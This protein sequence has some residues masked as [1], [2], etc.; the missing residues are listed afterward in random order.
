MS[1][2]IVTPIRSFAGGIHSA[3]L[4]ARADVETYYI[5]ART[6]NN[7]FVM[8]SGAAAN[9]SGFEYIGTAK[10]A[11]KPCR[12]QEWIFDD[13]DRYILE[14]GESYIRFWQ[15]GGRI[16]TNG[17]TPQWDIATFYNVGDLV[18]E[19][20][21]GVTLVY[22]CCIASVGSPPLV[23]Q[24]PEVWRAMEGVVT[25]PAADAVGIF[26][27]PSPYDDAF[28]FALRFAQ[29]QDTTFIAHGRYPPYRLLRAGTTSW[30]MQPVNFAPPLNGP[31]NLAATKTGTGV[32]DAYKVTAVRKEKDEESFPGCVA[33]TTKSTSAITGG[34]PSDLRITSVNYSIANGTSIM[35]VRVYPLTGATN[36]TFEASLLNKTFTLSVVTAN[37]FD[38]TGSSGIT[39]AAGYAADFVALSSTT[40]TGTTTGAATDDCVVGATA[41]G[42]VTGDE[43]LIINAQGTTAEA[44]T[45]IVYKTW[46]VTVL[47]ANTFKLNDSKGINWTTDVGTIWFALTYVTVN[48]G[49]AGTVALTWDIV[50]EADKYYVS[51]RANGV[52]GYASTVTEVNATTGLVTW[53]DPQLTTA[54][55]GADT[56]DTPPKPFNDFRGTGRFPSTVAFHDDRLVWGATDDEPSRFWMS[57]V[58]DYL[59]YTHS[60]PIKD[61]DGISGTIIGAQELR[62]FIEIGDSLFAVS[63]R[64]LYSLDV[65]QDGVLTPDGVRARERGRIGASTVAPVKI[66]DSAL[67]VQARGGLVRDFRADLVEFQKGRD[68]TTYAPSLFDGHTIEQWAFQRDPHSILW[69]V[70]DD[71]ILVAN[72]YVREQE[73]A[74]WHTHD[75]GRD[76]YTGD[77]AGFESVA[78]IP[79]TIGESL[80]AVVNRTIGPSY[81]FG[82]KYEPPT[83]YRMI[84]WGYF[85]AENQAIRALH[86]NG[87]H[88]MIPSTGDV[89]VAAGSGN[90]Q[91]NSFLPAIANGDTVVCTNLWVANEDG[92]IGVPL[93]GKM[94]ESV[95]ANGIFKAA[96]IGQTFTVTAKASQHFE[97]S[98]TSA[99]AVPAS[100]R[101]VFIKTGNIVSAP[102]TSGA[103][104]NIGATSFG[105]GEPA[106]GA[107]GT[108]QLNKAL[109]GGGGVNIV[110]TTATTYPVGSWV[111]IIDV[112]PSA[113]SPDLVFEALLEGNFYLVSKETAGVSF[114]IAATSGITVPPT[115]RADFRRRGTLPSWPGTLGTAVLDK[116]LSGGAGA[117]VGG[118]NLNILVTS[119]TTPVSG[120]KILVMDVTKTAGAVQATFE[121]TLEAHVYTAI[122]VVAGVSF[123]LQGTSTITVPA[124]QIM[125]F[126]LI[127]GDVNYWTMT[128]SEAEI[129]ENLNASDGMGQLAQIHATLIDQTV[130]PNVGVDTIIV[131]T[132]PADKYAGIQA[133]MAA[134]GV[135]LGKYNKPV[136]LLLAGEC[137]LVSQGYHRDDFPAAFVAARL[138]IRGVANAQTASSYNKVATCWSV[139]PSSVVT[140][141]SLWYPGDSSVDWV[142]IDTFDATEYSEGTPKNLSVRTLL[143]FAEGHGKPVFLGETVPAGSQIPDL[144]PDE[145]NGGTDDDLAEGSAA[146]MWDIWIGPWLEFLYRWPIVKM[147]R[148]L[149]YD[150]TFTGYAGSPTFWLNAY[151]GSNKFLLARWL[152]FV[153]EGHWLNSEGLSLLKDWRTN[154][155]LSAEPGSSDVRNIER[156]RARKAGEEGD[157][158]ESLDSFFV[159]SGLTWDGRNTEHPEWLAPVIDP[160]VNITLALSG[161]TTYLAGSAATLS[162]N[163]HLALFVA[164]DAGDTG[165]ML[166]DPESGET[167]EVWV[168]AY[169]SASVVTIEFQEDCSQ[170]LLNGTVAT[171]WTK[172]VGSYAGL[173][174]LEGRILN[175]LG[176][177]VRWPTAAVSNGTVTFQ[178]P[179]GIIQFGLPI[180][181]E[182]ETLDLDVPDG[183][184]AG[185]LVRPAEV[186][187]IVHRT[188]GAKFGP[189]DGGVLVPMRET[190]VLTSDEVAL[191]SGKATCKMRGGARLKSSILIRQSDPLPMLVEGL[192]PR[193]EV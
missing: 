123:Q 170:A 14:C 147:V 173:S 15:D 145:D 28:V 62:H 18:R 5:A 12:L 179:L 74:A 17:A 132:T 141:W 171:V 175:V 133:Q 57:R 63:N 155:G 118:A 138:Y 81:D 126:T 39:L 13:D 2:P 65:D 116:V 30:T 136:M 1:A 110:I 149:G 51:K 189:S 89:T 106:Y 71:G 114:E 117:G 49:S 148:Y 167:V 37:T 9:R 69:S 90:V 161:G 84:G 122:N 144:L 60:S 146:A 61:D 87:I 113:G 160:L 33:A 162:T 27:V 102:A 78:V 92:F 58:G 91:I 164:A 56:S 100:H 128:L 77:D 192:Y 181:A 55:L 137:N 95:Q 131:D 23:P 3:V 93:N 8:R 177:G 24:V 135:A 26:E 183:K 29:E 68:L 188:R 109:S 45:A 44:F 34:A 157:Y 121:A 152:A 108:T 190:P 140:D 46:I 52:F 85:L 32:T 120:T 42:L 79:D 115:Q 96:L 21:V 101:A 103:I 83:G 75:T 72:T 31:L 19:T 38:L 86:Q 105:H 35:C 40:D 16:V 143:E 184:I 54:G 169:T 41:H 70:R 67:F 59:N 48:H 153:R 187:A 186:T 111:E 166:T 158:D 168:T 80:Y 134:L 64:A 107:P 47:G 142:G 139:L 154:Q 174:R 185:K 182:I 82:A 98:G 53:S 104:L 112:D 73:I 94:T 163:A 178:K 127:T 76:I 97:L 119:A 6:L 150:Y 180:V 129:L 11:D 50:P 130:D 10:Y 36:A 193:A 159:D 4:D 66:D 156:M 88:E 125:D 20:S 165:F 99:I 43:I 172:M 151:L 25:T 7:V 22:Y 176:D 191:F 124:S